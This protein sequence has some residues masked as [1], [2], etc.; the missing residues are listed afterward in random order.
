M[1][2]SDAI[3]ALAALAQDSRLDIYRLLVQAGPA[4]LAAGRIGEALALAPATLS[5]HLKTLRAAGLIL[6]RRDGRS[7]IYALD[8][9]RMQGL[10]GYL[11]EHCCEGDPQDCG[12]AE[13]TDC[14]D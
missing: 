14:R 9:A 12:L 10:L 11:T 3:T 8:Y 2:K 5:F 1:H 7:L 4:G 6:Q 13:P